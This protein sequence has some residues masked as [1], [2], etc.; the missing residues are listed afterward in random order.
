MYDFKFEDAEKEFNWLVQEYKNHPLPI[1]LKGLSLWW[2][3]DAYS[4]L[5]YKKKN[6]KLK[7]LD[8][9]FL[10]LMDKSISISK[11]IYKNGN[12]IDGAFFLA[13]SY[14]FKGG[15]YQRGKSGDQQRW[16]DLMH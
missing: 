1:F 6:N 10:D 13:A 12:Q 4:G 8:D 3:I 16:L 15:Y 11:S 7:K 2:K 5:P 14:G 9:D